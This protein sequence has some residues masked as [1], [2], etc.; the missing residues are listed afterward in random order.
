MSTIHY[1]ILNLHFNG[2]YAKLRMIFNKYQS[3]ETAWLA[4]SRVEGQF[5]KKEINFDLEKEWQKIEKNGVRLALQD[6]PE[7]PALLKE[8]PHPPFGLYLKG[9]PLDNQPKV[10]IVG[11][12]KATVVG[13]DLAA[14]MAGKLSKAGVAVVSGLAMGID[15]AAHQGVID[16]RGKTIAVLAHGLDRIH[17]AQNTMLAKKIIE[18]GGTLVSEYPFGPV[19]YA[20]RFLE[21]NR[22]VSGF[23]LGVIVI[24]APQESGALATVRFAV[25][26][27]RDVFV[28][29]GPAEHP[30]YI[31]SHQLIRSGACLVTK[32]EEV[33]ADLNLQSAAAPEQISGEQVLPVFLDE[34][35]KKI[36]FVLKEAGA[37]LAVDKICDLSQIDIS[38][39]NQNL[40]LLF[41]QGLIKE[42]N[43]EYCL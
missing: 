3:W 35:Q 25:E 38:L 9:A 7:F 1:N 21:R 5:A 15:A 30:N 31:G 34:T 28:V 16:S 17:P 24:E 11:T 2:D 39:I 8:I 27:N 32:I 13:R 19:A 12:R 36:I 18:T 33:L 4:L 26:Q 22:I 43:G 20:A 41:I 40:T 37:P 23:S 29:P 10:A 14:K 6:D 42:E